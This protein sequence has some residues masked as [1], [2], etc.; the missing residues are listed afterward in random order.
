[1][2]VDARFWIGSVRAERDPKI[3]LESLLAFR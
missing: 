1:M 3:A 2:L